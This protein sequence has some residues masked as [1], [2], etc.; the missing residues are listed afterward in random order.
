MTPE[1]RY[2]RDLAAGDVL[3]DAAQQRAVRHTQRTYEDL[4]PRRPRARAAAS[5]AVGRF[6]GRRALRRL[7]LWGGVGRQDL[8]DGMDTLFECLPFEAKRRTHFHSFI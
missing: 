3:P 8:P 7:Y 1:R 4:R 5:G 2:Q 6:G